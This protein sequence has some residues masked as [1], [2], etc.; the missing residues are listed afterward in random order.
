MCPWLV[1]HIGCEINSL[2]VYAHSH[3]PFSTSMCVHACM[4]VGTCKCT[5]ARRPGAHVRDHPPS[6]SHLLTTPWPL[7]HSNAELA[8]RA[9]LASQLHLGNH[10]CLPKAERQKGLH[11]NWPSSCCCSSA[12]T[13]ELSP[14]PQLLY[15]LTHTVSFSQLWL[16]EPHHKGSS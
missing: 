3:L 4:R 5:C 16:C 15:S 8:D 12:L 6:P 7:T 9:A 11:V 2:S 1:L 13:T 10:L 14:S